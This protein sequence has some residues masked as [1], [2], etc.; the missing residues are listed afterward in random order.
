MTLIVAAIYSVEGYKNFIVS[1]PPSETSLTE[2]RD[3]GFFR[4]PTL[5]H[6]MLPLTI[7][8]LV[9]VGSLIV[10]SLATANVEASR[11]RDI[12]RWLREN[13]LRVSSVLNSYAQLS[14]GSSGQ[15]ESGSL[16]KSVWNR[17]ISVYDIDN[18]FN[19]M[20][21]IGVMSGATPEGSQILY[22]APETEQTNELVGKNLGS[23]SSIQPTLR[24]AAES[25]STTITPALADTFTTKPGKPAASNGFMMFTPFYDPTLPQSS[26][27]ER[28]SALR[29]YTFAIFR[30]DVFY[31]TVFKNVDLSHIKL[32]VYMGEQNSKNLM[33]KTGVTT[34]KDVRVVKQ[35]LKEYGQTFTIVYTMDTAY[36]MAWLATY[37]PQLLLFGGLFFGL[38]FAVISG[39]LLRN[40]YSRL[41]YEKERDVEFAKD[42]LLSLASHQLRTPATGVKQYLGMVLQGFAGEVS[43]KQREYLERAYASNNR[44]L[45]V[46]NDILH[47]AK[48][49]TGR[50]VLAERQF[51]LAKMVRDVVDEQREQAE[52]GEV[53]LNLEAPPQGLIVGDSHMLRMVLENLLSNAIKY[54]PTGGSVLVKMVRRGNRWSVS[55]KDTGVGIA[56]SDFPKLFKQFSRINNARTE[57]V[58]GT[59]VGLYLAYH[60]TV[61]HGGSIGVSSRKGKGT[62]FTVRLP[63]KI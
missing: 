60:L 55:V 10:Y 6:G 47:L 8:V 26:P 25:G 39:V 13:Q 11:S 30:G 46:I 33:Y 2:L 4:W 45:G 52:R 37:F 34:D 16:E 29:G 48:L 15:L 59:G 22:V 36:I 20:E 7:L 50:I 51:D 57:L 35:E 27:D 5:T 1:K 63:R 19:G 31:E 54:T 40:R 43:G 44:Q 23:S 32:S 58:T 53:K 49:E 62:T 17:F 21:A 18:N 3:N 61:L 12:D 9:V 38:M 42:E 56:K 14:W 41:T 24:R 28:R